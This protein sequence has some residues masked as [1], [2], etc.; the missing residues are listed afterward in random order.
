LNLKRRFDFPLGGLLLGALDR[1]LKKSTP[2]TACPLLAKYNAFSP[3]PQ[4]TSKIDPLICGPAST[5]S[6]CGRPISHGAHW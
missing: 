2:V 3:V 1:L 5:K 4:P 6:F